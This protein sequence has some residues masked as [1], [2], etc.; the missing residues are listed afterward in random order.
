MGPAWLRVR[1]SRA[2]L[3]AAAV[4][5]AALALSAVACSDSSAGDASEAETGSAS[6]DPSAGLTSGED[7]GQTTGGGCL[8]P[9][10]PGAEGT[11]CAALYQDCQPGLKCVPYWVEADLGGPP[12]DYKCVAVSGEL[13]P[14]AS[15]TLDDF[16]AA[17]DDCDGESFCWTW[18]SDAFAGRCQ[19]F[20]TGG[21]QYAECFA[22]WTC[23]LP[24]DD[25]PMCVQGCLPLADDCPDQTACLWTV[26]YEYTCAPEGA[27]LEPGEPCELFN[28][29]GPDM[30]CVEASA[31][32]NCGGETCCARHCALSDGDG[33]CEAID[34][35]YACVPAHESPPPGAEDLGLCRL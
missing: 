13:P 2:G 10:C 15:C 27:T 20:C 4:A 33:P 7:D 17:T 1:G 21:F 6:T 12:T 24:E 22:D 34:P 31:L 32:N 30:L 23:A 9:D 28:D 19:P 14:G 29:C 18:A 26:A 16:E 8:G 5:T 11:R 3:L 25:P 35:A